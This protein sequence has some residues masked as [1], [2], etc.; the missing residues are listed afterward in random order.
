MPKIYRKIISLSNIEGIFSFPDIL[1]GFPK[2]LGGSA[3]PNT[4][5]FRSFLIPAGA[6]PSQ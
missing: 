6:H 4:F 5:I 2:L 3:P 1:P